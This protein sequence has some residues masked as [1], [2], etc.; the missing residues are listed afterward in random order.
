MVHECL[1]CREEHNALYWKQGNKIP[2][3]PR[4][5]TRCNIFSLCCKLVWHPLVGGWL[6]VA[7]TFI[8]QKASVVK[9]GCD[10][11]ENYYLLNRKTKWMVNDG[12]DFG[13]WVNASSL[14]TGVS[15]ECSGTIVGRYLL[16]VGGE[17]PPTHKSSWAW[18]HH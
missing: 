13:V 4:V 6:C 14:A 1:V 8:K 7:V 17:R 10:H 5:V 16:A 12:C 2:D 9:I 15:L 18:R 3:I 11:K